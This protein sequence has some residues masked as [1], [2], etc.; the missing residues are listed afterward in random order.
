MILFF[1]DS[2][3]NRRTSSLLLLNLLVLFN[4]LKLLG[5]VHPTNAG[6][7]KPLSHLFFFLFRLFYDTFSHRLGINDSLKPIDTFETD[8]LFFHACHQNLAIHWDLNDCPYPF[9]VDS[10]EC[11]YFLTQLG[12]KVSKE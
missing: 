6:C 2:R 3:G 7:L 10:V 1:C 8:E 5:A 4:L 9:S 12:T 11:L